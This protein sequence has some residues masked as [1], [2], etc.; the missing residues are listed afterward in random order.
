MGDGRG[1]TKK[2]NEKRMSPHDWV[3]CVLVTVLCGISFFIFIGRRVGVVGNSMLPTLH[4]YDTIII[5]DFFYTPKNGDVIVFQ[6]SSHSTVE[7][8]SHTYDTTPL[9]KRV[10]AVEGQTID[11]NFTTG[12]VYVDGEILTEPYI[13]EPTH[14][15]IHFSGPMVVPS[16]H[17]F[18]MGDNRNHSSDS[19]NSD[20]GCVDTRNILGK[21]L[22]LLIPGGNDNVPRDWRRAGLIN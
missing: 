1:V 17:V 14:S 16:G 22:F 8:S 11:I 9:V 10:I 13:N 4:W 12:A 20:I 3:Q 7:T 15:Q 2:T 21:V 18:V 5:S 6:A 19:R